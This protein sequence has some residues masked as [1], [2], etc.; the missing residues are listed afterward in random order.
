MNDTVKKLTNELARLND[1][2]RQ[3]LARGD[4]DTAMYILYEIEDC[5]DDLAYA[6][7]EI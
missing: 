1:I 2:R 5:E 4:A 6:K 3:A 7:G